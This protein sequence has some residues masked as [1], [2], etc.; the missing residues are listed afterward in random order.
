VTGAL[1][2]QDAVPVLYADDY[3]VV[4]DKPAGLVVHPTYKNASGT[5]LDALRQQ[6]P[7]PPSIVGRLDRWTSGIVVVARHGV[8]HAALQRAMAAPNCHKD[9]LAIVHGAVVDRGEIDLRLRVNR[10]DRRQVVASR[11]VGASS[12]TWFEPIATRVVGHRGHRGHR[13]LSL[14]RCRLQTGR[15]HQIRVH[16][17]ASGWP[18]VGDPV[19]GDPSMDR[20]VAEVLGVVHSAPRLALH[21]WRLDITHPYSQERLRVTSPV[22]DDL[23]SIVRFVAADAPLDRE[24][25]HEEREAS[26]ERRHQEREASAERRHEEREASAERRHQ[27]REASAERRHQEREASAE[28][29]D[30]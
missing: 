16:L 4:V 18:I 14:L 9:Y 30:S 3:L 25:D 2:S 15:R 11:E 13:A 20:A 19:Y 21:A 22:P 28:R 29:W 24:I 12:L 7:E 5:L 1:P 6:M 10:E 8:V 26:A 27:E 17:T 23:A